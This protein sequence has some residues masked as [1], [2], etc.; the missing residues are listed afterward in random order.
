MRP[1]GGCLVLTELRTEIGLLLERRSIRWAAVIWIVLSLLVSWDAARVPA[2]E[3]G[4]VFWRDAVVGATATLGAIGAFAFGAA[5]QGSMFRDRSVQ[6]RI[7]FAVSRWQ[8]G[9]AK[10]VSAG[11]VGAV[12]AVVGLGAGLV[13]LSAGRRTF[14]ILDGIE[15]GVAAIL[16]LGGVA[17]AVAFAMLGVGVAGVLRSDIW[18][19]SIGMAWIIVF[20][21]RV[22]S[23]SL[24]PLLPFA[25]ATD[26]TSVGA[27]SS[28]WL[29]A[30]VLTIWAVGAAVLGTWRLTSTDL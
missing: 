27:S 23:G 29:S 20:E 25:A 11:I 19:V 14:D 21:G 7:G 13:A 30:L 2:P 28:R 3:V 1:W 24:R 9:A 10:L 22:A 26:L 4:A 12:V 17:V 18:T 8:V 5:A 16:C 15:T 6:W